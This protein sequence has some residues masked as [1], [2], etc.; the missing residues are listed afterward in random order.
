MATPIDALEQ[1]IQYE[2]TAHSN[3]W[4]T[5]LHL[6]FDGTT[7]FRSQKRRGILERAGTRKE[8]SASHNH[9]SDS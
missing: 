9:F 7:V 2:I 1:E 4:A 8:H 6:Q 5:G 3:V